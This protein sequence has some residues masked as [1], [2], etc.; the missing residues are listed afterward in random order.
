MKIY[1]PSSPLLNLTSPNKE[2]SMFNITGDGTA[3]SGAIHT[4]LVAHTANRHSP[5]FRSGLE[6]LRGGINKVS[7]RTLLICTHQMV[8]VELAEEEEE[9]RNVEKMP[10]REKNSGL[11]IRA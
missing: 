8:K 3:F 5:T 10:R 6:A 9:A 1:L 4:R 7:V 11:C 2:N